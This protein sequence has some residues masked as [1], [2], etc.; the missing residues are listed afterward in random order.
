LVILDSPYRGPF[1][2]KPAPEKHALKVW[3]VDTG[4]EIA[5]TTFDHPG[6]F[7]HPQVTFSP[8]SRWFALSFPNNWGVTVFDAATGK[9]QTVVKTAVTG[10]SGQN[11]AVVFSPDGDRVVVLQPG[12]ALTQAGTTPTVW[13]TATGKLLYRIEG[14]PSAQRLQLVFSPDGKRIATGESRPFNATKSASIKLW[15]AATGRELLALKSDQTGGTLS[16]SPD[17]NR[18]LLQTPGGDG[19]SWDATPRPEK[20]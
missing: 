15:D 10:L 11:S 20:R 16:F 8:D 14:H 4:R 13:E 17:G 6:N 5:T 19:P 2:G 7:K 1:V 18:L 9:E 3:E 12:A